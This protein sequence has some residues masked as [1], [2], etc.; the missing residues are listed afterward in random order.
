MR[1][2]TLKAAYLVWLVS[3]PFLS[4]STAIG[5]SISTIAGGGP[6]DLPAL[7]A[8]LDSP[9]GVA[10]GDFGAYYVSA[11]NRVYSVSEL[12]GVRSVVVLA[13]YG[14]AGYS[15]DGAN[16]R[17]AALNQPAGLALDGR[18]LYIAD[19]GNHCVRRVDL[20]TSAIVTV[21]G[22]GRQG[23]GADS[24]QATAI[25]LGQPVSVAVDAQHNLYIGDS[26]LAKVYRVDAAG[27]ILR[28][29]GTG[30]TLING[31]IGDGGFASQAGLS[32]GNIAVFGSRLYIVDPANVR[33]R[34]VDLSNS[35]IDTYA[36]N[37]RSDACAGS[38]IATGACLFGPA[39]L[40]VNGAGDLFIGDTGPPRIW[41]VRLADQSIAQ[42]AGGGV[43]GFQDGPVASALF[44]SPIALAA[45]PTGVLLVADRRNNRLRA[46]DS[47]LQN[48]STTAGNGESSFSGESGS[49]LAMS[50]NGPGGLV[51]NRG[52]LFIADTG[53]RRV[54]DLDL[55]NSQ[56][57]TFAGDGKL[58]Y[59]PNPS[60]D[61][62]N[63]VQGLAIDPLGNLFLADNAEHVL[64][65]PLAGGSVEPF[66][67]NG[68]Q[69]G[70]P[71]EGIAGF[72]PM[73][74]PRGVAV[75]SGNNVVVADTGNNRI[76]V[77]R[78]S[79]GY[80]AVVAGNGTTAY[81]GDGPA[82]QSG[83]NL[84]EA[85]AASPDGRIFVADTQNN[86]IRVI[87]TDGI[88]RRLAGTGTYGFSGNGGPAAQAY[89]RHPTA[90]LL[91]GSG[92][93]L[94]A[95]RENHQVRRIDLSTNLIDVFAG[96]GAAGYSGDGGDPT[97]ARLSLPSGLAIDD[98]GVVYVAD[99]GNQRIR[100]IVP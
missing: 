96:T 85:V 38:G 69:G 49:A 4:S 79:D 26:L 32:V 27:S 82:V 16:A 5:S 59:G 87:G 34:V 62:V 29:A 60:P 81:L 97:A 99:S 43:S 52:V 94:I 14:G 76:K 47:A 86:M 15:G 83:F 65:I 78:F 74:I 70:Q 28:I 40:A 46:I 54:R 64:R 56:L 13:G 25:A 1:A 9:A 6:D 57:S 75:D 7:A 30:A 71:A 95:D 36:G 2:W 50:L 90:L 98:K 44:Q 80:M 77:V 3:L 33:V 42:A 91:D 51:W 67:G 63:E 20:F 19:T 24:G 41:R 23:N 73:F 31:S 39:G 53:N 48:V 58:T 22:N 11:G 18:F 88:A 84:P 12:S 61:A 37:G 89:L 93:L 10:G 17:S 72:I 55:S 68:V 66:A 45:T 92:G 8:N 21:A 35:R 100:A